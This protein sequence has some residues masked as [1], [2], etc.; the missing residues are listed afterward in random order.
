MLA[1]RAGDGWGF[2]FR[3]LTM[4]NDHIDADAAHLGN[5]VARHLRKFPQRDLDGPALVGVA[6]PVPVRGVR[7]QRPLERFDATPAAGL[8]PVTS[9]RNL[10]R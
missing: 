8:W 4:A 6:T 2:A 5:R 3:N 9:D 1:V 7:A 10:H